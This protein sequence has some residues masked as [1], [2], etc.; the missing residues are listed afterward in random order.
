MKVYWRVGHHR[1]ELGAPFVGL[2]NEAGAEVIEVEVD[3]RRQL[4]P[5]AC[6]ESQ[7]SDNAVLT[8]RPALQGG[9]ERLRLRVPRAGPRGDGATVG[10]G[11]RRGAVAGSGRE[12]AEDPP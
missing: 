10:G 9:L 7:A 2:E 6:H 12:P 1:S 11:E 3:R 4:D 5:I 8:R